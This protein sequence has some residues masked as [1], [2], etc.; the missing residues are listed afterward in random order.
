MHLAP[1]EQELKLPGSLRPY[2]W[3]GVRF[4]LSHDAALLADE[5]GLGKTVQLAVSLSTLFKTS[6]ARRALVVAPASLRLNWEREVRRWAPNLSV[7][8]LEGDAN[9]RI[10]QYRLPIHV[11]I[12][13]YEQVRADAARLGSR[14]RF[15]VAVLDEAQRIKNT[16]SDTALACRI[17]R[18][19]RSWVLTGTP[20]ENRVADLLGVFRFVCP[21]LLRPSMSRAE[22]HEAMGPFFLRRRKADVLPELPPIIMQDIPLELSGRQKDAYDRLWANRGGALPNQAGTVSEVRLLALITKLKQQCNYDRDTGESSKL[23]ALMTIVDGLTS[24]DKLLVF[25][26]YVETLHWLSGNLEQL[27]P[28]E[29]FHGGL[30]Q[31][32]RD[33][34]LDRFRDLPGPR[35]LLVSLRAGGTGLNLQEATR[36]VL[37]DRWWNPALEAQAVNRAHRFGREN[38]LHVFRFL[39]SDSIEERIAQVLGEK[40]ELFEQYVNALEGFSAQPL[41]RSDLLKV[42]ELDGIDNASIGT[43]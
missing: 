18:R 25:S 17:L 10:Y 6:S 30:S 40:T 3:E 42:L 5:M 34:V 11:L 33:T 26:Q 31:A 28:T 24:Q 4:L 21:G 23:Q 27:L 12:A 38:V 41:S 36:V 20:V 7:R 16:D 8:K 15:D 37:F 29:V 14:V 39:V 1:V 43:R 13:S 19:D 9:E 35:V 32:D 22:M 2:Q